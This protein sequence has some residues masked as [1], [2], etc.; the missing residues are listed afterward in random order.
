[1]R[2]DSTC[3]LLALS[4]AVLL[5]AAGDAQALGTTTYVVRSDVVTVES[6]ATG[7]AHVLCHASDFATGG[8]LATT[9][10]DGNTPPR[11]TVSDSFPISDASGEGTAS[12]ADPHG[13]RV[14]TFNPTPSSLDL[15]A[16]VV[17]VASDPVLS[18]VPL[19]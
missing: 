3:L 18:L 12:G 2:R 6:G 1:M 5:V 14:I 19:P 13:W 17:C 9:A 4:S 7:D 15:Q 16:F 10:S 8:G 11:M